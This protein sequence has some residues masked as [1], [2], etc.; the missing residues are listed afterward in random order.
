[1]PP[2]ALAGRQVYRAGQGQGKHAM[3]ELVV[4]LRA[5]Y[6]RPRVALTRHNA[7]GQPPTSANRRRAQ[8]LAGDISREAQ[9]DF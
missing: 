4:A 5:V 7:D 2:A 1:V 3:G 9:Y 8:A 6:S